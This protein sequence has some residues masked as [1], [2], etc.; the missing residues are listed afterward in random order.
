MLFA[1]FSAGLQT[2]EPLVP[3]FMTGLGW[4]W[5]GRSALSAREAARGGLDIE[6]GVD[7]AAR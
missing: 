1:T 4:A 3:M 2:W 6:G 7:P 5:L